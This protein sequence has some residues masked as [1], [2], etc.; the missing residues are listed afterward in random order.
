MISIEVDG[1]SAEVPEGCSIKE[2]LELLGFEISM[3]PSPEALFM[4]CQTGGCWSCAQDI[5]GQLKPACIS[6]VYQGMRIKTDAS[7]GGFIEVACFTAGCNFCCPQCQNW[8][9]TYLNSGDLSSP[10]WMAAS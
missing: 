2:A 10:R 4:P 8:R 5:D 1:K 9:F 7:D 6:K 3:F